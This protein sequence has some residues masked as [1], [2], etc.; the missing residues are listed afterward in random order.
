MPIQETEEFV[1]DKI[2]P[3]AYPEICPS[4]VIV[5]PYWLME[6]LH[7]SITSGTFI[8]PQ[9]Y[10]PKEAWTQQNTKLSNGLAKISVCVPVYEL[11][12]KIRI[13]QESG[14]V[15]EIKK[16]LSETNS[17]LIYIQSYLSGLL[18]FVSPPDPKMID[19]A[20]DKE[21][22]KSLVKP[23][24]AKDELQVYTDIL[25]KIFS[26][27][28]SIASWVEKHFKEPEFVVELK[29]LSDFF[30]N[31]FCEMIIKDV[32]VLHK[33]FL[34]SQIRSIERK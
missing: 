5:R 29:K 15:D 30:N 16:V 12:T 22:R 3:S 34:K 23:T 31:V 21:F 8:T 11:I 13:A 2:S 20:K 14:N 18:D 6:T 33:K 26:E 1:E 4:S 9:V 28:K 25:G 32:Q 19:Q 10:L 27:G 17:K 7:K 24:A